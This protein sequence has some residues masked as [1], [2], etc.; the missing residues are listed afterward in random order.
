LALNLKIRDRIIFAGFVERVDDIYAALDVFIFPSLV[1]PSGTS[2]LA[3]MAWGLPVA[4]VA[5]GGVPE[6]VEDNANGLLIPEPDPQAIASAAQRL[7]AD[8]NLR[9]R[10]GARA[11]TDITERYSTDVMVQHFLRACAEASEARAR[12]TPA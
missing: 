3:A 11:R 8:V 4:A 2:L 12:R 5:R 10:L 1:E 6:Y 7:I 9:Q